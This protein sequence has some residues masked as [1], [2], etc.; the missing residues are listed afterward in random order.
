MK[1]RFASVK[2]LGFITILLLIPGLNKG[3]AFDA[4]GLNTVQQDSIRDGYY[5]ILGAFQNPQNAM[6]F[7]QALKHGDAPGASVAFNANRQLYYVYG[8][9]SEDFKSMRENW[10]KYRQ[11][12]N[13]S[14]AWVFYR[15]DKDDPF[16]KKEGGAILG[17]GFT[18]RAESSSG[19]LKKDQM[20]GD[21]PQK[22]NPG[23]SNTIRQAEEPAGGGKFFKMIFNAVNATSLKEVQAKINVVDAER[24]RELGKFDTHTLQFVPDPANRTNRVLVIADVF[25]YNK[26]QVELNLDAPSQANDSR[27]EVKDGV[28]FVNLDLNRQTKGALMIM[29]NVYFFNDAA[30][31]RPESMYE[32]NQLLEMMLENE[33]LVIRIH[34]HTNSNSAGKIIGLPKD[35]NRFFQ[36]GDDNPESIGSAKRLSAARAETVKKWLAYNGIDE[37]RIQVKAWGGKKPVYEKRSENARFNVRVEV[38]ILKD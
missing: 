33:D 25:G 1:T 15:G 19:Q 16:Y 29:Y 7:S 2:I 10:V 30:V 27:I 37:K 32:L 18:G 26:Q 34:G 36:L 20:T 21:N 3:M 22:S 13:Y 28:T 14:D 8:F 17:E 31:M 9:F 35:S 38:E 12:P 4:S 5:L 23:P 6:R 24:N 11:M